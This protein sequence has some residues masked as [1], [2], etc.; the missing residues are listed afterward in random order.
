MRWL[1]SATITLLSDNRTVSVVCDVN[2][3]NR[4]VNCRVT[5]NCTTCDQMIT[6]VFNGNIELR[7]TPQNNYSISVQVIREDNGVPVEDYSVVETLS[8]PERNADS[9]SLCKFVTMLAYIIFF[10]NIK[11]Y[12]ICCDIH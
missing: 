6:K 8:V 12:V 3:S 4:P 2:E 7:V 9:G 1:R 5:I 10:Y 11:T